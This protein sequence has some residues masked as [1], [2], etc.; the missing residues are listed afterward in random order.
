MDARCG[1]LAPQPDAGESSRVGLPRVGARRV[2]AI[3]I[4]HSKTSVGPAAKCTEVQMRRPAASGVT[5]ES[6]RG[7]G[8]NEITL[9]HGHA[10]QVTVDGDELGVPSGMRQS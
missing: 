5:R 6:D 8:G 2:P 4:D 9:D 3:R 10:R 7:A 1:S